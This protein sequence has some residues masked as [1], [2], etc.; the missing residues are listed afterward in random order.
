MRVKLCLEKLEMV[1]RL[2]KDQSEMERL[3]SYAAVV[4]LVELVDSNVFSGKYQ[5]EVFEEYKGTLLDSCQV[6]CGLMPAEDGKTDDDYFN[7]ALQAIKEVRGR[8]C[9]ECSF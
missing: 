7:G 9:V 4:T 6:M 8:Y 1:V 2:L 3:Q 5:H